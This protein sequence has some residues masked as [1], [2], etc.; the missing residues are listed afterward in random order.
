MDNFMLIA[1]YA[2]S[3]LV[4]LLLLGMIFSRLYRRASKEVSF[5]RT[6]FGGQKVIL[7]GGALVFPVLHEIIPVNM[8]TL[9][10]PVNRANEQAL[11]TRDRMRVDVIAEFYVRVKPSEDSIANAAQTLGIR[12]MH[13]DQLKELVEGKFVDA[14]RAVAAE[15][16]MTELH[17]QRVDFVQKVQQVVSEDLLKNGL[18]L[19]SVS[20]TGLDQTSKEYFNPSNAFDAEG[21][22]RLTEEIETR[23]KVRNDI[24]QDTNVAVAN[25]NLEAER[26]T[27]EIQRDVE[28][29]RLDQQREVEVRKAGQ[30]AE[31]ASEQAQ[32]T[33]EADEAEITAKQQVDTARILA[34]RAVEEE[35][36]EKERLIKEKDISREKSVETAEVE[37]RKTVELAEQDKAIAIAEKSKAQSEAQAEAD[38]ARQKAV[39]ESEMVHTVKETEIAER[40]KQVVLVKAREEAEHQAIQITVAAEAEKQAADDQ[41]ESIRILAN[42]DAEKQRIEATGAAEAVKLHAAAD[43]DRYSVEAAGKQAINEAS[44]IL[45]MEQIAMQVK[46]E[47]LKQMPE[48]IRESVKPM[49]QID[50]IKIIQVEGLNA[51][52]A[53][54][55]NGEGGKG[56]D[57]SLA[58]QLVN[59]ALRY[60]GQA[61][62]VDSL[63]AEIGLDGSDIKGLTGGATESPTKN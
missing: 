34:E 60:R 57:G 55:T 40:T 62:L 23:R 8:N 49:E 36:I 56:A 2:G 52:S 61:P 10:L 43:A 26:Q 58:D 20:L 7:N 63:L 1:L 53:G 47:L 11:I 37:Q 28:Y 32:K 35:R 50:G 16:A 41:A 31:I 27:L 25:K 42:A 15:M 24:E 13:P 19:E 3:I 46:L 14:L 59:S 5:V 45:S 39:K 29:A 6:G 12:T 30:A 38:Q 21:L 4:A 22:T 33:R 44:N 17:E 51:G 48:I 18:E 9:R 54:S